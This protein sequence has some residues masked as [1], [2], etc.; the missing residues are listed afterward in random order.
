[1]ICWFFCAPGS[2][3][4]VLG[5]LFWVPAAAA[6]GHSVKFVAEVGSIDFS[7]VWH[8]SGD[9]PYAVG[10]RDT[11]VT[12]KSLEATIYYPVDKDSVKG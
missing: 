10:M 9:S 3:I 4:T 1:M 5:L 7:K 8:P 12:D 2:P 11:K 6:W